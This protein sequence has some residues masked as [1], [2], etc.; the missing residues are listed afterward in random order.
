M[1]R[2]FGHVERMDEYSMARRALMADNLTWPSCLVPVFVRTALQ[3]GWS[4]VT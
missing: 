4:A 1:M 2:W 3:E